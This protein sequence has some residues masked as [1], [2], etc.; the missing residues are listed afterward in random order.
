[1]F[2]CV[3]ITRDPNNLQIF[4]CCCWVPTFLG[5][6]SSKCFSTNS[7]LAVKSAELN[8]YGMFH[9]RGPNLRLSYSRKGTI[10]RAA[11]NKLVSKKLT[12][13]INSKEPLTFENASGF[14]HS[15]CQVDVCVIPE[16][17]C[18]AV[19]RK[20]TLYNMGFHTGRLLTSNCFCEIPANV[21]FKPA[22]TPCGG[23]LVNLMEDYRKK[24]RKWV[25]SWTV[26]KINH[27]TFVQVDPGGKR[28]VIKFKN[29]EVVL[30]AAAW[31][32]RD[33]VVLWWSKPW[34]Y[35]AALLRL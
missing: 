21:R 1:M 5:P 13:G 2:I 32:R 9:P 14:S 34:T 16:H 10:M 4:D 7:T 35:H 26:H 24:K 20:A 8:S 11:V 29:L 30:P 28:E 19:W 22:R 33:C 25:W 31:W 12:G 3:A 18:T 17:T 23:S 15:G 27:S 6:Q